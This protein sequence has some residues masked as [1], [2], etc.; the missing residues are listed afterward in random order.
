[1]RY[2]IV[3]SDELRSSAEVSEDAVRQVY[4]RDP[5]VWTTEETVVADYI[6]ISRDD[7]LSP[8]DPAALEEQFESVREE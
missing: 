6:V 5:R 1:M 3:P 7:F 2:L 4:D 8:V